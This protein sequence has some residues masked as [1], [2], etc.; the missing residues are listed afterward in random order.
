MRNVFV[1]PIALLVY[2]VACSVVS[3][4]MTWE[5]WQ[6][7]DAGRTD[8]F[9]TVEGRLVGPQSRRSVHD[10]WWVKEGD[11]D[12]GG[13][14]TTSD[15]SLLLIWNR[16]QI[17]ARLAHDL[18]VEVVT[19]SGS[20]VRSLDVGLRGA[21]KDLCAAFLAAG[22]AAGFTRLAF[23]RRR[24]WRGWAK[25]S[26]PEVKMIDTSTGVLIALPL[27]AAIGIRI[28]VDWQASVVVAAVVVALVAWGLSRD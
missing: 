6:K 19:P 16:D 25:L 23:R 28:G 1:S 2:G 27:L 21:V 18:V 22:G 26:G 14:T 11:R 13:L 17:T 10:R 20:T 24:A 7:F 9:T 4:L 15:E 3:V 12:V 8:E 5:A